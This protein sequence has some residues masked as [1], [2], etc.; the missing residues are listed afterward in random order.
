LKKKAEEKYQEWIEELKKKE[1]SE[2]EKKLE[3][4]RLKRERDE[5]EKLKKA[6]ALKR[7]QENKKNIIKIREP[8]EKCGTVLINGKV[9]SYYDWSTSPQPSFV[10]KIPWKD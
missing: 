9:R 4:E 7:L 1:Q 10:N 2:R 3:E 5:Q 6:E 8:K